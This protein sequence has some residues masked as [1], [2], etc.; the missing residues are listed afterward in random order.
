MHDNASFP[1]ACDSNASAREEPL[2][3]VPNHPFRALGHL[4]DAPRLRPAGAAGK[5]APERQRW[6]KPGSEAV[7]AL[8]S[9]HFQPLS[10]VL[11]QIKYSQ[12]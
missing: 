9:L 4:I 3:A 10:G 6:R 7:K 8:M 12:A 11:T 2:T 5:G 1:V